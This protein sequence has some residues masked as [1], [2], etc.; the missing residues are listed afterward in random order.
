[1]VD[2]D[3]KSVLIYAIEDRHYEVV[4]YLLEQGADV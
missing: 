4:E 1:M 2:K 3:N